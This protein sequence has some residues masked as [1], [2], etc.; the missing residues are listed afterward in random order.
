MFSIRNTLLS[1]GVTSLLSTTAVTQAPNMQTLQVVWTTSAF[2]TIA[3]P[4]GNENKHTAGFAITDE[5]GVE[6]YSEGHP[7][8]RSPCYNTGGGRTFTVSSSC[9]SVP[10][11]FWC[12]STF[13][14]DPDKCG[15]YDTNDDLVNGGKGHTEF[16]WVG[17][18][19]TSSSGC[20]ASLI[21]NPDETCD[22]D[23]TFEIS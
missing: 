21:L 2:S 15:V 3:G 11:R 16:N 18:A 7:G 20:G 1:L 5:K 12:E 10:R 13:A 17:I 22:S 9:W 6:L 8:N 4:S 14:G 23:A 19:V